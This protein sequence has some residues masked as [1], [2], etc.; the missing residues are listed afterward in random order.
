MDPYKILGV[1]HSSSLDTIKRKF[2]TLAREL[3]P[4]KGGNEHMFNILKESYVQVLKDLKGRSDSKCFMDL[5]NDHETYINDPNIK[6]KNIN[7]DNVNL[8]NIDESTLRKQFQRVFTE[9]KIK[10]FDSDGYEKYMDKSGPVS[11][12]KVERK[13]KK[14]TL[15]KFNKEFDKTKP[16][17]SKHLLKKYNPDPFSISRNLQYTELGV[18]TLDDFSGKNESS[19]ELQY[20]D[21]MK[22]YTTNKLHNRENHEHVTK[23]IDDIERER[24]SIR[25]VMDENEQHT[26]Q[27]YNVK[28]KKKEGKRLS[29]L[30]KQDTETENMFHKV[31]RAM[32]KYK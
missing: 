24:S 16:I 8:E 15:D 20:M 9:S 5:K 25:Y 22:A 7:L 18:D 26:Y 30:N 3:H 11:E 27:K 14:F 4:D 10:T 17:N 21:Y 2:K 12:I 28:L 32:L 19:K 6:T 31:N 1:S 29:T 23:S 13:F